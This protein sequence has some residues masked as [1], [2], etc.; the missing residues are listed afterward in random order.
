MHLHRKMHQ[1]TNYIF[2]AKEK[3]VY[4]TFMTHRGRSGKMAKQNVHN[5]EIV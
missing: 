5:I 3:E 1:L 2:R 4:H